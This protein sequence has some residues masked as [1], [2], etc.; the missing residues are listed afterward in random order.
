MRYTTQA[1]RDVADAMTKVTFGKTA[2]EMNATIVNTIVRL[3]SKL[4]MSI[5]EI[6]EV[7]DIEAKV[8]YDTLKKQKLVK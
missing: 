3:Y 7:M 8:V 6:A 4:K 1:S 5:D 2:S